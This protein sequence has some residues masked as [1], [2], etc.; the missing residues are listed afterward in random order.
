V[1]DTVTSIAPVVPLPLRELLAVCGPGARLSRQAE[2]ATPLSDVTHD[3]R[4]VRAG[5]LFACRPGQRTDGH[6]HAPAALQA[7][8]AALLVERFLQLDVPQLKV[9]SVAEVLGPVASAVHGDPSQELL[10]LGVTGTN[11]KTTTSYMLES[12]LL[13]AGHT[14]GL[15][16]TVETRIAGTPI[17]GVRT[18]PESTDLQRLL[19][20]MRDADVTAA[21]MEVSSHGLALGRVR[22]TRFAAALFT[23]LTQ[24][25]LDFHADMEDYYAAKRSLFTADST[26]I[27]VINIDDAY[28]ARLADE[29][30][31]EVVRVSAQG[32]PAHVRATAVDADADGAVFTARLRSGSVR[33]RVELPGLYNVANALLAVAAAD[34]VG[35]AADVAAAGIAACRGIPGRMERVDAGQAF[36]VVVDYAHTPEA[37]ANVLRSVR[38]VSSKRI[39]VVIGCGGDR[40]A[41]KRPAMGRVAAELADLAIF[42]SDNPRSEDPQAILDAVVAGAADV[43]DAR[44]TAQIDRRAAIAAA[45]AEAQPGDVVVVAGK[46]HETTQELADRIIAFDDR[47]VVRELLGAVA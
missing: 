12:V 22:A 11:G 43:P 46:G 27:A 24:D 20:R 16:G 4:D 2:G 19:R 1:P 8:A 45:L 47:A 6:D 31:V 5:T 3:S 30:D 39:V 29:I 34:A 35:I 38:E 9:D 14:T 37:L 44:W 33:V 26:P 28:G 21:A 40:D 23:N 36:T 17:P 25:H 13:A 10:L 32:A 7:G 15:I 41:I 18:T 42:T